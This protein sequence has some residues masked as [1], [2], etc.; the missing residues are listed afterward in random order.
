MRGKRAVVNFIE[1]LHM[2]T[3]SMMLY[4]EETSNNCCI[5]VLPHGKLYEKRASLIAQLVKTPPAMQET[6]VQFLGWV[7]LLEKG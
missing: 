1:R 2:K 3:L 6:P 5:C 4:T 7:D